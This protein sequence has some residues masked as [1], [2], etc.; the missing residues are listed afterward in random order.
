MFT[1]EVADSADFPDSFRV[2]NGDGV[3]SIK[4]PATNEIVL[5]VPACK[6]FLFKVPNPPGPEPEPESAA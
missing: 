4:N 2:L 6:S 1:H 5:Q 3:V